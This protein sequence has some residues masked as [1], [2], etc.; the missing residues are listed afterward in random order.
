LISLNLI[1]WVQVSTPKFV[2][3]PADWASAYTSWYFPP[4]FSACVQT[5]L[6]TGSVVVEQPSAVVSFCGIRSGL[7][8]SI[9]DR[10]AGGG[11]IPPWY[12]STRLGPSLSPPDEAFG[13]VQKPNCTFTGRTTGVVMLPI[14]IEPLVTFPAVHAARDKPLTRG[15]GTVGVSCIRGLSSGQLVNGV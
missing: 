14:V 13:G 12:P 10:P 4:K 6:T 9:A 1:R 15:R 5:L 8:T 11:R 3:C 2:I 7:V